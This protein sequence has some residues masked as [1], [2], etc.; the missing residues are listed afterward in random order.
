MQK[1]YFPT[2]KSPQRSYI[3]IYLSCIAHMSRDVQNYV[4][5][6]L[7]LQVKLKHKHKQK[8][9]KSNLNLTN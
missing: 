6:K 5:L 7:C 2:Y 9:S 1:Q 8:I 4:K 3:F